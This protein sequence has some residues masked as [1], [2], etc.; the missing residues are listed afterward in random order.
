MLLDLLFPLRCIGCGVYDTQLCRDCIIAHLDVTL[1]HVSYSNHVGEILTLGPYHNP[2]WRRAIGQFKFRGVQKSAAPLG[3][4]LAATARLTLPLNERV[5]VT[6][7]PL[8]W[9]RQRQRGYNQAALLAQQ[10]SAWGQIPYADLLIRSRHTR[11]Q[12]K[13]KHR[14]R[15]KNV[16]GAFQCADSQNRQPSRIILVDDVITTGSTTRAAVEALLTQYDCPI[17]IVAIARSQYIAAA[18]RIPT[19]SVV[20]FQRRENELPSTLPLMRTV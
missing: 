3:A 5:I 11:P 10:L 7:I 2:F 13:K 19:Y 9:K 17:S 20:N 18:A 8:H 14:K 6:P 4:W 12:S 15:W 16:A 1:S